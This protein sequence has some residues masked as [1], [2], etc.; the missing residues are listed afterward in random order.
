MSDDCCSAH[1]PIRPGPPATV[2]SAQSIRAI[3]RQHL[4]IVL[5]GV[6]IALGAL[7]GWGGLGWVSLALYL[8]AIASP[9]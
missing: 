9:S 2:S 6:A 8:V 7:A 3:A 5:G 1:Q 4:D